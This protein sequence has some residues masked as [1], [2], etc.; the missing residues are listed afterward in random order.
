[1]LNVKSVFILEKN[2]FQFIFG[3]LGNIISVTMFQLIHTRHHYLCE[4][5]I[6]TLNQCFLKILYKK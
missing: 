5:L 6:L 4:V 2:I 1:M 3:I